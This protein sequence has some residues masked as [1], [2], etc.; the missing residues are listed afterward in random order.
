MTILILAQQFFPDSVGGSARVAFDQARELVHRGHKVIAVVPKVE[1]KAHEVE[2]LEGIS[3]YRYGTGTTHFLGQSFVD[4]TQSVT[5]LRRVLA[6]H[7]VDIIIAHQPTVGFVAT[8][9]ASTKKLVYVFHASV[10]QEITFQGLT[11]K[12]RGWKRLFF[13]IFIRWMKQMEQRVI[14]RAQKI[15]VLSDYSKK[16]C[17]ELYGASRV[18]PIQKIATG[19]DTYLFSPP[20]SK[21]AVRARIGIPEDVTVFLTV[22]RLVPRMGLAFLIDAVAPLVKTYP[23]IRLYIV[24]EGPLYQT[25][26][27]QIHHLNLQDNIVLTGRIRQTDLPLWYKSAD[28]FVLSTRAYEGLGVATLEALASG[29]PVLG[30]PVGATE[31]LLKVVDERL[32]FKSASTEDMRTGI[33]WFLQEG[34]TLLFLGIKGRGLVESKYTWNSA[35]SELE[36]ALKSI[37]VN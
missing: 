24:G 23:N 31:E 17:N 11:G 25:L 7:S 16:L 29:L 35:G 12:G 14:E 19:I 2:V 3:L 22:R 13:W 1:K 27:K 20:D 6:E 4:R 8:S 5:I 10:P 26:E 18:L 21:K 37:D 15:L 30:T 28:C 33:E 36:S 32:L 34:H 9:V